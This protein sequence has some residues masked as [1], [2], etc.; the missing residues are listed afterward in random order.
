RV[1]FATLA[2]AAVVARW[3]RL[4][5]LMLRLPGLLLRLGGRRLIR[6]IRPARVAAL[7]RL[8]TLAFR[9]LTL[10]AL[11]LRSRLASP[12]IGR[13]SL[14]A[15]LLPSSHAA[16]TRGCGALRDRLGCPHA[17]FAN[18][19]WIE[20]EITPAVMPARRDPR[21]VLDPLLANGAA[22]RVLDDRHVGT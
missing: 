8:G 9:S 22:G 3:G 16:I 6:R 11:A 5:P 21:D 10:R 1:G 18:A 15:Y 4:V 17:S 20:R 7:N 14:F 13:L 2:R 19:L 12:L